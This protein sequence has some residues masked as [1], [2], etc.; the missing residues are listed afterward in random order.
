VVLAYKLER[1]TPTKGWDIYRLEPDANGKLS[2]RSK[3]D[4]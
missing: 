3:Y 1:S 2:Y 4:G